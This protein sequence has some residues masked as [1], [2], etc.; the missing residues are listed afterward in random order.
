MS[1]CEECGTPRS[2]LN[3]GRWC[4]TCFSAHNGDNHFTGETSAVDENISIAGI[5][6]PDINQLPDL[7]TNSISQ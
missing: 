4:K 6:L 2:K 5:Q 1:P 3:Q 7:S